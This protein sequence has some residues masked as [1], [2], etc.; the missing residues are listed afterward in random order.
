MAD[1]VEEGGADFFGKGM[2]LFQG[3]VFDILQPEADA[4]GGIL[5][6]IP[7]GV[8][9]DAVGD[10]LPGGVFFDEDRHLADCVADRFWQF[11]DRSGDLCLCYLE[12]SRP[13]HCTNR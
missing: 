5:L 3:V 1:F 4:E 7:E 2:L 11:G 9:F 13:V 12:E 8:G 10:V 6:E